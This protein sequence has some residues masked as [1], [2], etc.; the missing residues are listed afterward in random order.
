[1]KKGH[2][3]AILICSA[4]ATAGAQ[5]YTVS[6]DAADFQNYAGTTLG[7]LG[8]T[9]QSGDA[10]TLDLDF[11]S[12]DFF[13]G[14]GPSTFDVPNDW[15]GWANIDVEQSLDIDFATTTGSAGQYQLGNAGLHM[16]TANGGLQL[17]QFVWD[18]NI[19]SLSILV[20][21]LSEGDPLFGGG[22]HG[23]TLDDGAPAAPLGINAFGSGIDGSYD[24][25]TIHGDFDELRMSPAFFGFGNM[26]IHAVSWVVPAPSSMAVLGL[27][28]VAIRRRRR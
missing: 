28:C 4:S 9:G 13:F 18:E 12:Q 1:M 5:S 7:G 2:I 27:G 22:M 11:D 25:V 10:T 16:A 17:A 6:N 3:A 19:D 26:T 8:G 20:S 14:P 21:G 15:W 24:V 23:D